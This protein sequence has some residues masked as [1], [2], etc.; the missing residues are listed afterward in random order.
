M[1][2]FFICALATLATIGMISRAEAREPEE[3]E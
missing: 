3:A 2:H 1:K